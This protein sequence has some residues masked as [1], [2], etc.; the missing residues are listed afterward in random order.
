MISLENKLSK[1][2]R[3]AIDS[4]FERRTVI[5]TNTKVSISS[6]ENLKEI[7]LYISTV[8]NSENKEFA[9]ETFKFK[10]PPKPIT[11]NYQV[12][13]ESESMTLQ[14]VY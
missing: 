1:P 5:P 13:F 3:F 2:I 10:L 7:I 8:P 9:S 12:N 11:P 6:I 4:N 14:E